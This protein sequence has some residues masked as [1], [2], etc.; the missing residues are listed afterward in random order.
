[1]IVD[2]LEH[3]VLKEK[4][5]EQPHL[6]DQEIKETLDLQEDLELQGQLV[7]F[8]MKLSIIIELA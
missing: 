5:D 7:S 2:C 1:M 4:L 6:V 3:L 8:S